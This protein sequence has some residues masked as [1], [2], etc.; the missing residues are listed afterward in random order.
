MVIFFQNSPK[1]CFYLGLFL[2]ITTN[3]TAGSGGH[4][5][6]PHLLLEA[7][8]EG[9]SCPV[10]CPTKQGC[11]KL[12]FNATQELGPLG[13]QRDNRPGVHTTSCPATSAMFPRTASGPSPATQG[14][15]RRSPPAATSCEPP[16]CWP[17]F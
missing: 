17:T 10:R 14:P 4:L 16:G 12:T 13:T 3:N 5:L 8:S 6:T 11:S 15:A 1:L 2:T 9:S 7:G